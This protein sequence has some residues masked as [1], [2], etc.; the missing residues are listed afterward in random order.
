MTSKYID[1]GNV[2][3]IVNIIFA[4]VSILLIVT[5]L[6]VA[7]KMRNHSK[8]MGWYI[9][10]V[11]ILLGGLAYQIGADSPLS[12]TRGMYI[13][14]SRIMY[15]LVTP[16][17]GMY[18]IE[19]ER[20][21]GGK[22]DGFFWSFLQ[23][24]FALLVIILSCA[25]G[26][27]FFIY[28]AFLV[29]FVIMMIMLLISSKSIS[30][31][32]GFLIG[33]IFPLTASLVGMAVGRLNILGFGLTMMLLIV[34]F[35]YQVETERELLDKQ[36]ELSENK[37]SL[38]MEQI[39][40]HFIYN[41]LQQIALLCDDHPERVKDGILNF[42]GYLRKNFES[43][44]NDSMIPFSQEM[45]HVHMYVSLSKILPSRQFDVE[46]KFGV[47]DFYIPA[48]VIQPLVENAI[49]YGI[50]MSTEGEKILIETKEEK[51]YIV[52]RVSDDGHGSK[53]QLPT[54]KKHKSVGTKNVRTRLKLLCDGE[55]TISQSSEGTESVIKIPKLK[56][57]KPVN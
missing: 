16:V 30:D 7:L 21:E 54:Q 41:S 49:Q 37:V 39:H 5:V 55:L 48:L 32:L 46:E 57:V 25:M 28:L 9:T 19:T 12:A 33:G 14:C 47:T 24:L 44:T 11:C 27:E 4:F 31:S 38:L 34:F 26:K 15:S 51:G 6:T 8:R 36:I 35:G 10:S 17:F 53:T 22:W 52:V 2:D 23:G 50:A 20:T 43:L 3:N 1:Y 40:P 42:S 45:E 29:Q 13:L 56:A 18:F